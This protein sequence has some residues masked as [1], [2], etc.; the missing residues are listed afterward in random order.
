MQFW[1]L[2]L[3]KKRKYQKKQDWGHSGHPA[4][5]RGMWWTSH[6]P[7][8]LGMEV[9]PREKGAKK[10]GSSFFYTDGPRSPFF[11]RLPLK[12]WGILHFFLFFCGFASSGLLLKLCY[13]GQGTITVQSFGEKSRG[14]N[15]PGSLL[16]GEVFAK[17]C[18]FLIAYWCSWGRFAV[19]F[20]WAVGA[21]FLWKMRERGEGL[22]GGLGV[23]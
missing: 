11:L 20:G 3:K 19:G 14:S 23:G 15:Y 4:F 21:V 9:I 12:E 6:P 8:F 5:F 16:P 2:E 1:K 17:G 22:R 7:F 10:G 18:E 13:R